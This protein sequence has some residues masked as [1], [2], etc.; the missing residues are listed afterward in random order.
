[1]K[2]RICVDYLTYDWLPEELIHTH[3]AA[4]EQTLKNSTQLSA[5]SPKQRHLRSIEHNKLMRYQNALWRQMAKK[6][7]HVLGRENAL[8]DP[9]CVNWQKASDITCR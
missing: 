9:S 8:I 5:H 2:A 1:M 7:T 4:R 3:R 6:C